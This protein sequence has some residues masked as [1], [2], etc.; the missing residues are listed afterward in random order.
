MQELAYNHQ[1]CRGGTPSPCVRLIALPAK[2]A[3]AAGKTISL[4]GRNA[5]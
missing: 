3:K 5:P 2:K 1:C 4:G